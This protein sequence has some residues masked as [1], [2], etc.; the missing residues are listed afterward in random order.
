MSSKRICI[1]INP[2]SQGGNTKNNYLYFLKMLKKNG[3]KFDEYI[4]NGSRHSMILVKDALN[5]YDTFIGVGGDGLLHEMAQVLINKKDKQLGIIPSGNGN[6]FASHHWV[7]TLNDAIIS[8]KKHEIEK[9]DLIKLRFKLN[10]DE[11][12]VY[13]HCIFGIGYISDV[14]RLAVGHFRK[15]GP[16]A[17][18]PLSG[19]LGTLYFKSYDIDLIIDNNS[20][21]IESFNTLI[22]LNQGKVGPINIIENSSDKDGYL[23]YVMFNK[24]KRT[25]AL[26]ALMDTFLKS[27]KFNK[28]RKIGKAKKIEIK[29][30][31]KT[32][33]MIDG[34]IYGKTSS[35]SAEII[36]N[37]LNILSNPTDIKQRF[38]EGF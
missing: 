34:E 28:H 37:S 12:I 23:D 16:K 20:N 15:L 14:V 11:K 9:I 25:E 38:Q 36:P 27:Y 29:L 26:L 8:I 32:D 24:T 7:F 2:Y 33:L 18:Y 5:D 19:I 17:C 30:K 6:M 10:G 3:I 13:S 4:T 21:K 22:G 31:D 35:F 1:I